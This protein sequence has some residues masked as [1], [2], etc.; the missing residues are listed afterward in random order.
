MRPWGQTYYEQLPH[1]MTEAKKSRHVPSASWR[2]LP[3]H[4]PG[5]EDG[6]CSRMLG[7]RDRQLRQIFQVGSLPLSE[8]RGRA[9][10]EVVAAVAK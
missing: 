6:G 1:V 5:R 7:T 3:A 9:L 2:P 10:G 8:A 4:L